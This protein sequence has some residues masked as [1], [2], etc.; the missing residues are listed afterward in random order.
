[1]RMVALPVLP[2][3]TVFGICDQSVVWKGIF[4]GSLR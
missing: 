1:V 2:F 3:T 4:M